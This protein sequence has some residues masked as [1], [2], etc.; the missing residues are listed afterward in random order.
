[1]DYGGGGDEVFVEISRSNHIRIEC[2]VAQKYVQSARR[3]LDYLELGLSGYLQIFRRLFHFLTFV[4]YST[5][6][7]ASLNL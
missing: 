6:S 2:S 7:T 3:L 5:K 1:V 4:N